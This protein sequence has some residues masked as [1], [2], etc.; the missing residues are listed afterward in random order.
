MVSLMTQWPKCYVLF[1]DFIRFLVH[2]NVNTV[3]VVVTNSK[4]VVFADFEALL[5]CKHPHLAVVTSSCI[6]A[7]VPSY[8]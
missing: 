7:F 8:Q 5:G 4:W 6:F 1:P 2:T 3:D